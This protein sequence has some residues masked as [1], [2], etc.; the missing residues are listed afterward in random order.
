MNRKSSFGLILLYLCK[1]STNIVLIIIL[2]IYISPY[3][4]LQISRRALEKETV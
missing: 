2:G 4:S 3:G 1:V